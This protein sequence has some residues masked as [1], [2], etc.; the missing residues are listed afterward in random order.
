MKGVTLNNVEIAARNLEYVIESLKRQFNEWF[1][2][3]FWCVLWRKLVVLIWRVIFYAI[4]GVPI[5]F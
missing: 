2:L 3:I 5:I 4:F 1:W